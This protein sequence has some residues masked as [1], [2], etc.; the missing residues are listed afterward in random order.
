MYK[1]IFKILDLCSKLNYEDIWIVTNWIRLADNDILFRL[2]KYKN[3]SIQVS[4]HSRDEKS[5]QAITQRK[6]GFKKRETWLKRILKLDKVLNN[7]LKIYSN[8]V[9]NSINIEDIDKV[10]YYLYDLGITNIH[11]SAIY[12]LSGISQKNKSMLVRYSQII[13]KI[14]WLRSVYVGKSVNI[15]LDWIPL[16]V[17]RWLKKRFFN[18]REL[19]YDDLNKESWESDR[20]VYKKK[21]K[22]CESCCVYGKQ[23]NWVFEFYLEAFWEDEFDSLSENDYK[24]ICT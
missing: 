24:L 23:C 10:V 19:G 8:T 13:K 18:I 17:Y 4:V 21:L 2:I 5:E 15:T 22:K 16:C 11:L 14:Y 6:W 3:L 1:D 9:F 20:L 7:K 12:S